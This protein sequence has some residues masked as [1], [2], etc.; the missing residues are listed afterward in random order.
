MFDAVIFDMDGVVADS[1]PLHIKAENKTL[2]PFKVQ[3]T[4][5]DYRE[6]MGRSTKLLLK[7]LIKKYSLDVEL[8]ELFTIH[9]KNLVQLY[10][11]EVTPIKGALELIEYLTERHYPL[12]L[13]SSSS[14]QL[15]DAVISKF[16]I[17]DRFKAVV[18]GSEVNNL[19]PAPDIF[20]KAAQCLSVPPENSLV[21]EDSTAGVKAAKSAKM[22]CV[23]FRSPHSPEQ[24]FSLADKIINDLT[25]FSDMIQSQ[26]LEA[27]IFS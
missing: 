8:E 1:E 10:N 15:V 20:L 7:S 2:A 17:K 13:A 9:K 27:V 16:K 26:S 18:S 11:S 14:S 4:K 25:V 6:F 21:I 22:F 23:G 12:A 24:D 19:K 3:V 5:K